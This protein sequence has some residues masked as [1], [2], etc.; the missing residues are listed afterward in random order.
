MKEGRKPECPE[1]NPVNELQKTPHLVYLRDRSARI[2]LR[3][4]ALR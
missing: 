1:K 3:S 2:I 4:A